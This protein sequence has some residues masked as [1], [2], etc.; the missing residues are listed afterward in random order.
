MRMSM[1]CMPKC[2]DANQID[3]QTEAADREQFSDPLQF[4]T[5][6]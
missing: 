2:S 3:G 1:V 5:F 6:G 4:T